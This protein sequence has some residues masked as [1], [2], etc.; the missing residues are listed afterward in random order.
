MGYDYTADFETT[1]DE[2]DC[3]VWAFALATI[4]DEPQIC[5]GTSIDDFF[6]TVQELKNPKIYFHNLKFDGEFIL[7]YLLTHGYE[8]VKERKEATD[9]S[10]VTM[11][12]GNGLFYKIEVYFKKSGHKVKKV[13]FLD[14]LKLLNFSVE[15]VAKGFN[16][17]IRK[18]T[19]DYKAKR[20]IGHQLTP[21]EVDYICNDVG[22]MARALNVMFERGLTKMT[23]GSN[24]LHDYKDSQE[25]FNY[26]YPI[27]TNEEDSDIRRAYRGGWT[28]LNPDYA[29]KMVGS[30][31]VVDK[32]SMYPSQMYYQMLPVGWPVWFEEKYEEDLSHPLYVQSFGCSFE[33]KANKLPCIQIKNGFRF[34]VN[35][36]LTSSDGEFVQLTLTSVDLKLFLE[37]YDVYD[38]TYYGGWKFKEASGLF[39][40]YIDNWTD[41][42]IQSK[43]DGN[44]AMYII[45]KLML[46]SL[47]GKFGTNPIS[48]EKE[49]VLKDDVVHYRL[50]PP[51]EKNPV[52][53]PMA[54]FIT[55]YAR[56][57][58]I[59]TAQKIV[60][61]SLKKY[62]ENRFIYSD[63]DSIHCAL[64]KSD[65]NAIPGLHLDPYE[66]GAWDCESEFTRAKFLR[67]KCYMEE[68][69]GTN[70]VHIAGLPRHLANYLT[71]EN[72]RLGF[73]ISELPKEVL[74]GNEKLRY[75]HCKGGV[76]LKETDFTIKK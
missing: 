59:R 36:W 37:N 68:I 47:Y 19:L 23:I 49:P 62:G 46:N 54:A 71:F 53:I 41:S 26:L 34:R 6:A 25:R 38:L 30:G 3:R 76:V 32:N 27:L 57:D 73:N 55:A 2:D 69:D 67:Q 24:A 17:P 11:I 18:L 66:L 13:T 56:D 9:Y 65:L 61:Y 42:K 70:S 58:I 44:Q 21:E 52:Y 45:S 12:T 16:L 10:F 50:L 31:C 22:I 15:Q 72:F 48:I 43:K 29:E 51:D 5:Y 14:S 7:H 8:W 74:N 35:E 20:E 64:P 28:Y 4:E 60:D 1:T 63:T 33:L 39:K 75:K 40:D